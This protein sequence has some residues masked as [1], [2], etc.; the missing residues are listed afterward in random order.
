MELWGAKTQ[1]AI[2]RLLWV[3]AITGGP[4]GGWAESTP[5]LSSG[6]L[7]H[8]NDAAD[9]AEANLDSPVLR[10]MSAAQAKASAKAN[11][12]AS[13]ELRIDAGQPPATTASASK[14]DPV[15][16]GATLQLAAKELA[17][18]TGAADA[19]QYLSAE[20]GLDKP[21]DT[22]TDTDTD[23]VNALR[24]RASGEADVAGD[25]T[26]R[27]AEQLKLDGEQASFLAS[28]LVREVMPWAVGAAGL[29]GCVQA[30][31]LMLAF[32]RRKAE[33]KRKRRKFRNSTHSSVSR[34][35]RL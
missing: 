18:K 19:K 13:A 20:L 5:S 22:D 4:V 8:A 31:R 33:R 14:R 26:A 1:R 34:K 3:L 15:P 35:V 11:K 29:L 12:T 10:A 32:S 6:V 17:V 25:A 16:I 28:A 23:T 2:A 9:L 7:Q 27:S 24:R 30:L 21:A